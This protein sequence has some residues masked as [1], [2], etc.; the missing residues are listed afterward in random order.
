MNCRDNRTLGQFGLILIEVSIV[1]VVCCFVALSFLASFQFLRRQLILESLGHQLA[2]ACRH[3]CGNT[4]QVSSV[5]PNPRQTCLANLYAD[6]APALT[7]GEIAGDVNV[8]LTSY[9]F[10]GGIPIR[11]AQAGQVGL[12]SS[13]TPENEISLMPL[14]NASGNLCVVE[15]FSD[16]RFMSVQYT[17][18]YVREVR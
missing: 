12:A 1:V 8:L 9:N 3:T 6:L 15:L 7:S 10:T 18:Q 13:L 16:F 11:V 17:Q 14:A 4:P 2:S 5:P